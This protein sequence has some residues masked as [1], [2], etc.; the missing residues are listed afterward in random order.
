MEYNEETQSYDYNDN[1][2]NPLDHM[3]LEALVYQLEL[4]EHDNED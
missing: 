4:Q 2:Y 1:G 3:T